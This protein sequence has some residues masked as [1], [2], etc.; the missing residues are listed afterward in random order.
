M[1]CATNTAL[2]KPTI[3]TRKGRGSKLAVDGKYLPSKSHYLCDNIDSDKTIWG[4]DLLESVKVIAIN[5]SAHV[6]GKDAK[7]IEVCYLI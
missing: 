5:I 3:E 6:D 2:N 7:A 4:V 1:I